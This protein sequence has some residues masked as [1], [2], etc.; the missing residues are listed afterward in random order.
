MYTHRGVKALASLI[1]LNTVPLNGLQMQC[2]DFSSLKILIEAFSS[3]TAVNCRELKLST[4]RLT[5]R[6]VYH[7]ILLLT[8]AKY[9]QHFGVN[10]NPGLHEAAPLLLSV[11]RNLKLISFAHVP[12][13]DQELLEMAQI[14]QSN[15]SL[16]QLRI[17]SPSVMRY[18]LESITKFVEIVTA[19][20]SKSRLE[21]L[22]F[23]QYKVNIQIGLE[24]GL[25]S[26]RLTCMA[27]S[28]GNKLVLQPVFFDAEL[29]ELYIS[30]LKQNLKAGRMSDSLLYG[31][32]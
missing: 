20:E 31:K 24:I 30:M 4:C 9:L 32:I 2:V 14:L 29:S 18:S 26:Y 11:A 8:Q 22:A 13:D 12:I 10:E 23:G 5:S 25:L 19:P 6:H 21:L 17:E 28:R 1:T 3:P 15:T 7:L 16:I 27:A